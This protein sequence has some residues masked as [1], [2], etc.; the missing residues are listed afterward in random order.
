MQFLTVNDVCNYLGYDASDP[1][2]ATDI[3]NVGE[4][5]EDMVQAYLGAPVEVTT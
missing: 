3:E 4:V 1:N 5:A 2:L